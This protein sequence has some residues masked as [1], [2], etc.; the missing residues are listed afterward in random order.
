MKVHKKDPISHDS[1]DDASKS[2]GNY[3]YIEMTDQNNQVSTMISE[4]FNKSALVNN[5]VKNK[6]EDSFEPT[7]NDYST[8]SFVTNMERISM[9]PKIIM[10]CPMLD[11]N[12]LASLLVPIPQYKRNMFGDQVRISNIE[13][14]L[15][16]KN[17]KE[18]TERA[19]AHLS[20]QFM[21]D[22]S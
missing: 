14:S 18:S 17:I 7:C 11:I 15:L 20:S 5:I 22:L 19:L 1:S 9:I 10:S 6:I 13:D 21:D 8:A 16:E 12:K 4:D 3:S 2:V